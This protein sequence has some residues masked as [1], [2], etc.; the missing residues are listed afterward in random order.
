MQKALALTGFVGAILFSTAAISQEAVAGEGLFSRTYTTETVPAG[1]FELEQTIRNRTERAF[2]TYTAFDFKSEFE[3]GITDNFQVA[4]YVNTQY[5][6]AVNA[7]DDNDPSG[8]QPGGLGFNSNGWNLSS[9]STEF[10]YRIWSP[11]SDPVGLAFYIEPE[12]DF[13]D[14]HN[15]DQEF[16]SMEMEF[17]FLVQKNLLEDQLV[18]AYNMVFEF[19]Y[20]RYQDGDTPFLGELDWNHEL[21]ASYRFASNLYGGLEFR[22]HNEVGNFYSHDHSVYWAGPVFHYGGPKMWATLGLLWQ[23][24]GNPDGYDSAGSYQGDGLFLHS[25][26]R[27]ETTLKV[28]FPF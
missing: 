5:M 28:G 9:L 14:I 21:G 1:H 24:S 23:F 17:R 3:Y 19:E 16:N 25:H 11:V 22:N 26:E 27:Y 6:H 10:L 13:H 7:P 2:G 4:F 12:Y 15:G 18:L 20:F 8:D